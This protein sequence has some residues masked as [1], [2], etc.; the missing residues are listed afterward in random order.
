MLHH[1][2][3]RPWV[4]ADSE[5]LVQ[6]IAAATAAATEEELYDRIGELITQNRSIHEREC[7]NLN[8]ATNV[9]N[10]RAEAALSAGL[11]SRP[12]L[13][14]PGDKYEMGLEA[15]ERIEVVTAE[16]AAEIFGAEYAEVRVP[17]GALA[18]LYAFMA[19]A[20][21]GDAIIDPPASIGGHVTHHAAGVAGLY[22]LD[23][24]EA[25]IDD[26]SYT[27][28]TTALAALVERVSPKVITVGS[29]LNLTHHPVTEIRSIAD[30][31]GAKVMFDAAHLSGVI[32]GGAWPSPLDEGA[33]VMTMS[34]YK[35][36]GGPP[37]GLLLTN[38]AEVAE[39]VDAIA[40]PG[41]TANFDAAKTAALAITMLDWRTYG[42][43]YA[44]QMVATA[45]SLERELEAR[46]VPVYGPGTQSH[47]LA[48][49]ATRWGGGHRAAKTL[50]QANLLTCAIGLPT[51]LE[52]GLRVGTNE[53]VRWAM[54]P[55]N[56]AELASLIATA[57]DNPA[58]ALPGVIDMR[59]RFTELS[60]V[61]S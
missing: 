20:E 34:T 13:G 5:S 51:D 31:V 32:A 40:Y 37:S 50:R 9:M 21:P 57:L 56:M 23:I 29:S 52:A 12:S 45:A 49:D 61:I 46:E 15:I 28:D 16:L 11:G 24:H 19:L 53:I 59:S 33:H 2:T 35:S 47:A 18:N 14:Y 38:E 36:L 44:A 42:R 55:D 58:D 43:E 54:G 10:P 25:P 17:S 60:Y 1:L 6:S 8:P 7:I 39:R 30:S 3:H 4:P 26:D 48:I 27:I 41:L 22:H